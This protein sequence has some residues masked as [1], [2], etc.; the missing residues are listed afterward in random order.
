MRAADARKWEVVT[1]MLDARAEVTNP[2]TDGKTLLDFTLRDF[3]WELAIL[4][5]KQKKFDM[6]KQNER[7]ELPLNECARRV[8]R[9]FEYNKGLQEL[10]KMSKV[11]VGLKEKT[12]ER[13]GFSLLGI[14]LQARNWEVV[15]FLF[16]EKLI[17]LSNQELVN[18]LFLEI[19]SGRDI[20]TEIKL[21]LIQKLDQ[22]TTLDLNV[23]NH[24]GETPLILAIKSRDK[25]MLDFLFQKAKLQKLN[26]D[27]TDHYGMS[28]LHF[29]IKDYYFEGVQTL[30]ANKANI[31]LSYKHYGE[32]RSPLR[33]AATTSIEIVQAL[34]NAG[35]DLDTKDENDQTAL[36]AVTKYS[37]GYGGSAYEISL[38]LKDIHENR[39]KKKNK[40]AEQVNGLVSANDQT[41][42]DK[43]NNND[44]SESDPY[45]NVEQSKTR[46]STCKV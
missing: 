1:A 17:N 31:N 33:L 44:K 32:K 22:E 13:A 41:D 37:V 39:E 10:I 11:D 21:N 30:I 46:V 36:D 42:K 34:V 38:Y 15:Q 12:G 19:L 2:T 26:I 27:A 6:N 16:D 28:A 18:E 9:N 14:I 7:H 20:K 3:N 8:G 23:K 40:E 35:A 4:L 45:A 43:N 5:I 24:L 25:A 29:A